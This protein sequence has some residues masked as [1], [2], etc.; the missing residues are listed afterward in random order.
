MSNISESDDSIDNA[1]IVGAPSIKGLRGNRTK[2]LNKL[3]KLIEKLNAKKDV[4]VIILNQDLEL[5]EEAFSNFSSAHQALVAEI[6]EDEKVELQNSL[7]EISQL[8]EDCKKILKERLAPLIEKPGR[9]SEQRRTIAY[10][11]LKN[12]L[13]ETSQPEFAL[14]TIDDLQTDLVKAAIDWV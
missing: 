4:D 11:H 1:P 10:D 5:L 14:K 3:K 8:Y 6:G 7:N 13:K 9:S 12:R 2:R